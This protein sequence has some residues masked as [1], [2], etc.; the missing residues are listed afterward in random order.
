MKKSHCIFG[1]ESDLYTPNDNV[2]S[3]KCIEN[4]P[5]S[6]FAITTMMGERIRGAIGVAIMMTTYYFARSGDA[7]GLFPEDPAT[8][9]R[10]IRERVSK[11]FDVVLGKTLEILPPQRHVLDGPPDFFRDGEAETLAQHQSGLC[12]Q[13][14][15]GAV[16]NGNKRQQAVLEQ[17][18]KKS[19][20]RTRATWSRQ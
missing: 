19:R 2:F 14:G 4:V 13:G 7:N 11:A 10:K 3:R 9:K 12:V 16:Q 6:I 18:R 17:C 8:R 20:A 1:Y 15:N 5:S